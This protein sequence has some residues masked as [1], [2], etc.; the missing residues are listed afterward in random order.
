MIAE[1][2][3]RHFGAAIVVDDC[4]TGLQLLALNNL[5]NKVCGNPR[6]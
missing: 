2:L 5:R 6:I 3:R 1:R 4:L